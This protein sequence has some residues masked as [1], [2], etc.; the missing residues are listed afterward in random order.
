MSKASCDG[1][2]EDSQHAILLTWMVVPGAAPLGHVIT[3]SCPPSMTW[4]LPWQEE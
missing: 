3:M 1:L 2:G 4:N